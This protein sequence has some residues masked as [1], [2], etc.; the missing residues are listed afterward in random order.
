MRELTIYVTDDG[1]RYDDK[2]AA[3]EHEAVDAAMLPLL[4]MLPPKYDI[5]YAQYIDHG[6]SAYVRGQEARLAAYTY[7]RDNPPQYK[8]MDHAR[9]PEVIQAL[10]DGKD[11]NDGWIERCILYESTPWA[12]MRQIFSRLAC[13]DAGGREYDQQYHKNNS[14]KTTEHIVPGYSRRLDLLMEEA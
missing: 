12:N 7:L 1:R 13:M 9:I 3:Q 6:P 4:A 11:V 5:P 10:V 14:E 8:S 2:R